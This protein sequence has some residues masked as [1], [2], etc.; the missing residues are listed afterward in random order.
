MRCHNF[1]IKCNIQL[2]TTQNKR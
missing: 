2:T 1:G